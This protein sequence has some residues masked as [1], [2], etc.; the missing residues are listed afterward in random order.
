MKYSNKFTSTLL[1]VLQLALALAIS[2]TLFS[3]ML[4]SSSWAQEV[5]QSSPRLT[6]REEEILE[7]GLISQERYIAGGLVGTFLVPFGV[8]QAIHGRYSDTGWIFTVSELTSLTLLV[9]GAV[10]CASETDLRYDPAT[11]RFKSQSCS[12]SSVG[13][14]IGGLIGFVGFRIWELVDLWVGAPAH[15]DRYRRIKRKSRGLTPNDE[16]ASLYFGPQPTA[17]GNSLV[18][19]LQFRF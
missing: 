17:M 10:S 13:L 2:S 12:G 16:E 1:Q 8:G 5:R 3:I 15:N 19:G 6:E 14:V 9:A 18:A 7:R 11:G 4:P